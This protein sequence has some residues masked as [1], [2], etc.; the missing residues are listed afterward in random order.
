MEGHNSRQEER[1]NSSRRPEIPS[2]SYDHTLV[3]NQWCFPNLNAF[4]HDRISAGKNGLHKNSTRFSSSLETTHFCAIIGHSILILFL[5][6][7]NPLSLLPA[8]TCIACSN[9]RTGPSPGPKFLL[10]L[11]TS[12]IRL[13]AVRT[14]HQRLLFRLSVHASTRCI[15]KSIMRPLL[16]RMGRK[17]KT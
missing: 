17:G 1:A 13:W 14:Y 3:P 10:T 11:F 9:R 5:P 6:L 4:L 12:K 8:C 16:H 7:L 2:E 15:F